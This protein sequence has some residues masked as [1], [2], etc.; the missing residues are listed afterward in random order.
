ME[1]RSPHH[2]TV[3]SPRQ[4]SSQV[5]LSIPRGW[6]SS[7]STASRSSASVGEAPRSWNAVRICKVSSCFFSAAAAYNSSTTFSSV[8]GYTAICQFLMCLS[9]NSK[10]C[11]ISRVLAHLP[12]S[13]WLYG[14]LA[15]FCSLLVILAIRV[16]CFSGSASHFCRFWRVHVLGLCFL[17][18][19]LKCRI[20]SVGGGGGGMVH[21]STSCTET[22]QARNLKP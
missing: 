4:P 6:L 14:L 21:K 3:T 5:S 7:T 19:A 12:A 8:L 16:L 9:L 1:A 18:A 13:P 2:Q 10:T 17:N 11:P 15:R 20:F 22:V